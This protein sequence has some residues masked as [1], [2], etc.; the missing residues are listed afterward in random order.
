MKTI[1]QTL[2]P[3]WQYYG[4]KWRAAP[5]YPAPI[6]GTI[7]EPF[8]G[9][10]G[11]SCR[12][13]D[14]QVVLVERY[15]VVAEMWRY[16]IAVSPA[17]VRAIP[18]VDHIDD[19]PGWVPAGGRSLVGFWLNSACVT[20]RKTLS[21]GRKK[22]RAKGSKVQGWTYHTRERIASQVTHIRHWR[23]IEGDWSHAPRVQ[24]TWFVDPPYRNKAG[25]HYVHGPSGIDFA[26]LARDCREGMPGQVIVCEND[27]ADWLPFRSFGATKAMCGRTS[28]EVIWTR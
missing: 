26:A 9:A 6:Y 3:F 14:R 8:A 5:R 22:L 21:A 2:K 19:L 24:A 20:P 15:P 27:G 17:E 1:D 16:M 18:E 25:S 28:R 13:P 23:V 7:I 4:G 11:Y 12:Y 10:A